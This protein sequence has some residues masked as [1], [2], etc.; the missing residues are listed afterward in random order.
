MD[1]VRAF[2]NGTRQKKKRLIV[3]H[4]VTQRINLVK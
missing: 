1:V 3:K 2:F 4:S